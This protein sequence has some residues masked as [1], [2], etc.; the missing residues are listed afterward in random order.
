MRQTEQLLRRAAHCVLGYR[1]SRGPAVSS[2]IFWWDGAGLWVPAFADATMTEALR[3]D[4]R[5]AIWIPPD[6]GG[7]GVALEAT[8]RTYDLGDP[9]SLALHFPPVSAALVA[10]ALKHRQVLAG[11]LRDVPRIL[12]PGPSTVAVVIRARVDRLRGIR[13]PAVGGGIGPALPSVVPADIRRAVTGTREVTLAWLERDTLRLEP[14]VWDAGL[15]LETAAGSTPRD[16]ATACVLASAAVE[17]RQVPTTGLV[18]SGRLRDRARLEPVLAAWWHGVTAGS[19]E[20]VP[21]PAG[22]IELPD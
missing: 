5:C 3:R 19:A 1:T 2:T 10:L 15:R 12:R 6:D 7:S 17:P 20:L 13:P 22:G 4:G 11:Y 18:L 16:S 8:A 14:A 21:E 9:L